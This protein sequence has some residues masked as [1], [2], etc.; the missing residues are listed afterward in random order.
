MQ[1]EK[2]PR[3][4]QIELPP[5]VAEGIYANFAVITHSPSEFVIDFARMVPGAPKA[6]VQGRIIMTPMNAKMLLKA[7]GDNIEKFEKQ[8]GEIKTPDKNPDAKGAIGFGN[9]Q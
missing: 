3:Q 2:S 5:D 7:L 4:I 1:R 9:E 6:K 8:F